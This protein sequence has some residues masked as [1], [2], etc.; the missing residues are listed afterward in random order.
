MDLLPQ[1]VLLFFD[2]LSIIFSRFRKKVV[3]QNP[4]RILF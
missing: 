4:I 1:R 3:A 2:P